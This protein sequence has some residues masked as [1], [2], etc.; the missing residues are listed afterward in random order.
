MSGARKIAMKRIPYSAF[1]VI[2]NTWVQVV[3]IPFS[4]EGPWYCAT[5]A[6]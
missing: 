6:N 1:H 5:T 2:T 3:L 4:L